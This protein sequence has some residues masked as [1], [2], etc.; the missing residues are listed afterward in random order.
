MFW[1]CSAGQTAPRA[2]GGVYLYAN[3]ISFDFTIPH[4]PHFVERDGKWYVALDN[5]V[6]E[7][8]G[9]DV[10]SILAAMDGKRVIMESFV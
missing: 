1:L 10:T 2:A 7:A 4:T 3:D 6:F 5:T 8:D 9:M